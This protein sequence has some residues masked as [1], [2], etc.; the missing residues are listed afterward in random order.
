MKEYTNYIEAIVKGDAILID[1]LYKKTYPQIRNFILKNK[2]NIA[3]AEDIFQNALI[4]ITVRYIKDKHVITGNIEAYVFT[5]CKNLWRRKFRKKNP[6][7]TEDMIFEI[8]D[9]DSESALA[10]LEQM[11]WELFQEKLKEVKGKCAE[12]LKMFFAKVSN[13]EIAERMGYDSEVVA[14]QKVYK[15]KKNLSNSIQTD[16]RY[17]KLLE[18]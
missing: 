6:I 9:D 3:D 17:K 15:C 13:T 16:K 11:R 2:G 12:V 8:K 1:R 10:T 4:Q 18:L 7:S 14:R 5:I